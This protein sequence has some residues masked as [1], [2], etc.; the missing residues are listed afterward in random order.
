M[1]RWPGFIGGSDTAQSLIADS[2][3]TVNLY[4][5]PLP[6]SGINEAALFPTP[7]FQSWGVSLGDVGTRGGIYA[8]GRLFFVIGAGFYEFSSAGVATKHGTVALDANPAQ[9]VYNGVVGGQ[10][11][12]AAGGTIYS[13]TLAS[14][15]LAATVLTGGFTMLAFANASG[16]AFNPTT[17]KVYPSSLN[18]L[19]TYDLANFFRRSNF[20]DPWQTIF[21]DPNN[22]IWL[23]GTESFEVWY[24]GNPTSTQPFAPLSGLSDKVGIAAPFAFWVSGKSRGWLATTKEGGLDVVGSMGGVPEP[25][26]S[27]AVA[28]ALSGYQRDGRINDA[29]VLCYREEGHTFPNV[30]FPTAN[31]TWSVDVQGNRWAERGTWTPLL[32][33]YSAWTPSAHVAAFGTHLVGDRTTGTIWKM[34]N[35]FTTEMDGTS[36]RRLRRAPALTDEL[37]RHPFDR[38]QLLM[39]TGVAG[40]NVTPLATM[41]MSS[42]GG[43][44]FGNELTASF[45]RIGE[46]GQGVYWNRLGIPPLAVVECTWTADAPVRVLDAY[47]NNSED[48]RR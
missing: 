26:S 24:Y 36:I 39:D 25:I 11:G 7:G 2:E 13:F 22:L 32:G 16:L 18:D 3:R 31:A 14:N 28:T 29:E 42:D 9:L 35:T 19:S 6:R 10:I 40:Q 15:T 20:P 8:D 41:R 48:A 45:G 5:E 1:P 34:D 23:V 21:V 47:L 30:T 37:K 33:R 44:T 12:I 43:R 27:Y 17:G 38:L 4:V 46:Y